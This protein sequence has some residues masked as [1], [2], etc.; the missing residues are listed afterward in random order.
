[1]DVAGSC[2]ESAEERLKTGSVRVEAGAGGVVL[3]FGGSLRCVSGRRRQR[4]RKE[5]LGP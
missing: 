5:S 1:M 3:F 2:S 4:R